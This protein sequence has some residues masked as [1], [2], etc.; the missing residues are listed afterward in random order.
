MRAHSHR[1]RSHP[2][3]PSFPLPDLRLGEARRGDNSIKASVAR[4]SSRAVGNSEHR[5]VSSCACRTP[6]AASPPFDTCSV[7]RNIPL[8][9]VMLRVENPDNQAAWGCS[10]MTCVFANEYPGSLTTK[11]FEG[12]GRAKTSRVKASLYH[13]SYRVILRGCR[14]TARPP[15]LSRRVVEEQ[16]NNHTA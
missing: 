7:R 16:W 3:F 5:F 12:H 10:W 11:A 9:P 8:L 13:S 14:A 6:Y 15:P 2:V 4:T 1:R